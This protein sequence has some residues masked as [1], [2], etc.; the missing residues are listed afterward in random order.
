MRRFIAERRGVARRELAAGLTPSLQATGARISRDS[1]WRWRNSEL[2]RRFPV[3]GSPGET[4][5]PRPAKPFVRWPM[6][7]RSLRS[8]FCQQQRRVLWTKDC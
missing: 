8:P 7:R 6:T 2:V 1:H 3:G 5:S 4:P